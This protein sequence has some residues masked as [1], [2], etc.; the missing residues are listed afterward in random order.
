MIVLKIVVHTDSYLKAFKVLL[1]QKPISYQNMLWNR[2][3]Y[4]EEVSTP[5]EV[6]PRAEAPELSACCAWPPD[7]TYSCWLLVPQHSRL[8]FSC[9]T[10]SNVAAWRF[11][12]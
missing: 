11:L 10:M 3:W 5:A 2:T 12:R 6:T 9:P 4:I 8:S 7:M 1:V